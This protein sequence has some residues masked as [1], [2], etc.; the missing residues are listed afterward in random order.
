MSKYSGYGKV[1]YNES[2]RSIMRVALKRSLI[3]IAVIALTALFFYI[4]KDGLRD[5]ANPGKPVDLLGVIYFTIVTITTLGYG[6]IVPVTHNSRLFDAIFVTIVRIFTYLTILTTAF[7]LTL[8]KIM[9]GFMIKKL[10]ERTK[11]HTI[12]CGFGRIGREIL[13]TI[14]KEGHD[15]RQIVVIDSREEKAAWAAEQGVAAL[16]GN[17][18]NE[19]LLKMADVYNAKRIFLCTDQDHTNLMICLTARSMSEKV[20][21]VTVSLEKENVKI[22]KKSGADRVINIPEL[23]SVE[24]LKEAKAPVMAQETQADEKDEKKDS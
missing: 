19:E 17:A 15:P 20:E 18:E 6:D 4:D 23:L 5:S 10:I 16:R 21:I 12:I 14:L 13:S 2:P 8:P 9:E 7:E 11:D 3:I 22:F 1:L 24:M